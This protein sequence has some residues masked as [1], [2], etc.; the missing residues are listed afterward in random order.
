MTKAPN[1]LVRPRSCPDNR[2]PGQGSHRH[3]STSPAPGNG[4]ATIAEMSTCHEQDLTRAPDL[5]PATG[6]E[7]SDAEQRSTRESDA[8]YRFRRRKAPM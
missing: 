2:R 7:R 6:V 8:R 5:W 1:R 3:R 4:F